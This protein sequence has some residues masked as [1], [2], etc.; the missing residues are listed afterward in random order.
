MKPFEAVRFASFSQCFNMCSMAPWVWDL[1]FSVELLNR[2]TGKSELIRYSC[3]EFLLLKRMNV[4]QGESSLFSLV[5]WCCTL[6]FFAVTYHIIILKSEYLNLSV[7]GG[8]AVSSSWFFC[9]SSCQPLLPSQFFTVGS[10]VMHTK[11][12]NGRTL[13]LCLGMV[14]NFCQC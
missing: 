8:E 6:M 9:L 1:M 4:F 2:F 12:T 5:F 14:L 10:F 7:V 3:L 11:T 13:T